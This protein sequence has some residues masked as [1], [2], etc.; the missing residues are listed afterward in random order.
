M[1]VSTCSA[2]W[3]AVLVAAATCAVSQV[4]AQTCAPATQVPSTLISWASLPARTVA[5]PPA[6]T[7]AGSGLR[8]S[9]KYTGQAFRRVEQPGSLPVSCSGNSCTC[10]DIL[11]PIEGQ[12]VQGFS[13]IRTIRGKDGKPTGDFLVVTDNGFGGSGNSPDA[14]LMFHIIRPNFAQKTVRVLR[15]VFLSDPNKKVPFVIVNEGTGRRLLTGSDFDPESIQPIGDSV[16]IGEEFGPYLV[17]FNINTGECLSFYDVPLDPTAEVNATNRLRSPDHDSLQVPDTGSSTPAASN[18]RRSRG[19]E[20]MAVSVSPDG[21]VY[22]WPMLEG[23]V[24]ISGNTFESATCP[25]GGDALRIY[26]FN[27]NARRWE[28]NF[29]KYATER[30]GGAHAIGDFNVLCGSKALVIERDNGQGDSSKACTGPCSGPATPGK[31]GCFP[32]PAAFKRIYLIDLAPDANGFV[33]KE[34]FIDLL[35]IQDPNRVSPFT[36]N[37]VFKFPFQTIEDVDALN[38]DKKTIVV[39]NDNNFPFSI[40]RTLGKADNNE[41]MELYVPDFFTDGC[42]QPPYTGNAIRGT[43]DRD[44]K[45][46]DDDDDDDDKKGGRGNKGGKKG[47]D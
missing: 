30:G 27:V 47:G 16:W 36:E 24:L 3:L 14:A 2:L 15:T 35:N 29:V 45:D 8:I 4:S 11:L 40:A 38:Y 43:D 44:D 19:F 23:P 42:T 46:D 41:V 32:N 25:A 7:A 12:P 33:K 28:G 17:E 13:G 10:S 18:V 31:E 39:A 9:G 26:K 34:K 37:N 21:T 1:A 5:F 6:D 20:G 22:L